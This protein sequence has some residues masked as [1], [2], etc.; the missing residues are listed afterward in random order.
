MET[1]GKLTPDNAG[2][3]AHGMIDKISDA[4]APAVDR[5][6]SGAHQAVDKIADAANQ[7]AA[8]LRARSRRLWSAKTQTMEQCRSYVREHP[9]ISVG[10]AVAAGFLLSRLWKSR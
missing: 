6:T 7:T 5:V 9:M 8:T 1:T 2:A 10:V 3:A 4:T